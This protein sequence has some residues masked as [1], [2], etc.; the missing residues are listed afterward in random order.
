MVMTPWGESKEL[1]DRRLH[2]GPG[3]PRE[4]VE[5]NQRERLFAAM[6]ATVA[7]KVY[8]ATTFADLEKVSGVSRQS[9]C[10]IFANKHA[11]FLAMIE[12]V[13]ATAGGCAE[14]ADTAGQPS[15]RRERAR[16]CLDAL[17]AMAV[18]QPAASRAVL[19]GAYAAGPKALEPLERATVDL[20]GAVRARWPNRRGELRCR[21]G[22]SEPRS[23]RFGRSHSLDRLAAGR[24]SCR[25]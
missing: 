25:R 2:P 3:T 1:R 18:A 15:D 17:A 4:V 19:I 12:A 10:G 23:V 7:G 9:F 8:R 20:E 5:Q 13:I 24:R 11:C 14:A 6:A 16:H 22:L 21:R